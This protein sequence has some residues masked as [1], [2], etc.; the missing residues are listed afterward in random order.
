MA[1]IPPRRRE[2]LPEFEDVWQQAEEA[3]GYVPNSLLIL[4]HR[5]DILR[6]TRALSKAIST[7][8]DI[9][10]GLKRLIAH[11]VSRTAGCQYCAAHTA[12]T[13]HDLGV[14]DEKIAHAFEYETSPLFSEAERAAL[15]F[16][17]CAGTVPNSVTEKE[18]AELRKHYSVGAIVEIAATI[19]WFGWWNRWNDTMATPLEDAPKAFA[20][21]TLGEAGWTQ[22]KHRARG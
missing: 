17:Q 12:H 3:F 13:A 22:G 10:P 7:S 6:A 18:F 1:H 15:R 2:E 16:A 5:P 4:G 11:V 9:A 20:E 21:R 8:V 14:D 19:A